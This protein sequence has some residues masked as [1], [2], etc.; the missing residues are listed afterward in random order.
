MKLLAF[1]EM[2]DDKIMWIFKLTGN[3][4]LTK[5][6]AATCIFIS[7]MTLHWSTFSKNLILIE[8]YWWHWR[9]GSQVC[10]NSVKLINGM[11]G[12]E[13]QWSSLYLLFRMPDVGLCRTS[14]VKASFVHAHLPDFLISLLFAHKQKFKLFF[15]AI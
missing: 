13:E 12:W 5:V 6:V 8:V 14:L 4:K 2:A 9:L 3:Y 7:C 1:R 15:L 11:V 10:A